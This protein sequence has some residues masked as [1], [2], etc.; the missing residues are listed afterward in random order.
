M[1]IYILMFICSLF[2]IYIGEQLDVEKN[3]KK[4]AVLV[5]NAV[6]YVPSIIKMTTIGGIYLLAILL[7]SFLAGYRDY[8][9]GTDVLVYGNIWFHNAVLSNNF[10]NYLEWANN[11]SIGVLYATFNYVVSRFTSNVHIFYFWYSFVETALVLMTLRKNR[12][13][14]VL[15]MSTYYF[16]F[17]NLTLNILRQSLA[18]IVIVWGFNYVTEKKLWKYLLIVLIASGF[19]STAMIAIII[20]PLYWIAN[21]REKLLN[22][23]V[24]SVCILFIVFSEKLTVLALNIGMLN[25]RYSDYLMNS[26]IRGGFFAH[27]LF[28]LPILILYLTAKNNIGGSRDSQRYN[29][30]RLIVAFTTVLSGFN[31]KY[32][33]LGRV[34]QY[35]D[36]LFLLAVPYIG[37]RYYVK[38][39]RYR[40]TIVTKLLIYIYLITYWIII[41]GV[42]N[43]GETVPYILNFN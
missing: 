26:N 41:Y 38:I 4:T 29:G 25:E 33:Y 15:G 40:D 13:D 16:L 43:S 17:F 3:L 21:N 36:F 10:W 30:F 14:I 23:F 42:Q 34:T 27:L 31:L 1:I 20:Y 11:S 5:G 37:N 12:I 28:C 39:G 35:F 9:I 2:F 19:H 18:M 22:V 32:V 7:T 24:L 6:F 8:T